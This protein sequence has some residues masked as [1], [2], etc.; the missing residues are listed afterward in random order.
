M[1][2]VN[3]LE[4][5]YFYEPFTANIAG[6]IVPTVTGLLSAC[7][8]GLIIYII[9]NSQQKLSTTYHRLMAF[10]SGFDIISSIFIALG[11]IML[12]SDTMYK[13]AGPMLGN[14]ITCQIQGSL[15]VFGIVGSTSIYA[16]LAWYFVCKLTFKV[17]T[18]KVAR[19]IEP[20]MYIYTLFLSLTIPTFYLSKDLMYPNSYDTFCTIVP[21][22][23]R[24]DEE[25]W[26]GW[27][28]CTW[29]EGDLDDYF[30]YLPIS[31]IVIGLQFSLIVFGMSIILWTTYKNGRDIK[32]LIV[33]QNSDTLNQIQTSSPSASIH[34]VD[35]ETNEIKNTETLSGLK[36]TRVLI[37]QALMYIGAYLLTWIF[38]F[39]SGAFNIA[40]FEL[41]AINSVLF[42]LQG[43]WNLLIFLYDK[44]YL[45]RQRDEGSNS[46]SIS[47][48]QAFK[49]IL[50]SPSDTPTFVVSQISNVII[51]PRDD[52]IPI[53]TSESAPVSYES[54]IPLSQI[55]SKYDDI[56]ELRGEGIF[57]I[58]NADSIGVNS[59]ALSE[60]GKLS[61]DDVHREE[62]INTRKS[63]MQIKKERLS[64]FNKLND[65]KTNDETA[66]SHH[67]IN[68]K[69]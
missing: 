13:F 69:I 54:D 3:Q 20:I 52:D 41:D 39:L 48:W 66:T 60:I 5:Y 6:F 67:D 26:Y 56:S 35:E 14:K 45:I 7:S 51:E 40:S 15:I 9:S 59:G 44:T 24:C 47:L 46:T 43:F 65:V 33:Q 23:E 30:A 32:S 34:G 36:Y 68:D 58:Q 2:D 19:R 8:S 53:A 31:F 64:Y 27:N 61:S 25:K 4:S 21:Y 63:F 49:M 37:Y 38:T 12:P 28:F 57:S 55:G 16:C 1:T 22:P 42:P 18:F 10:M 29:S 62:M 17:S 50:T 11:T